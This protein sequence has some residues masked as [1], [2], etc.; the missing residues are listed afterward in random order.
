MPTET[1]KKTLIIVAALNF[2]Y[3][4]VEFGV[5]IAIS[6][7]S[8][9]A[10]SVDFLED[11][12]VNTLIV[13][14]LG[15]SLKRRALVGKIMTF[16]ICL[17]ALVAGIQAIL[18]ALNPVVPDPWALAAT[19]GGAAVVN[20]AC[21]LILMRVRH[22]GGSMTRGA[23]LIARND[24]IVNLLIIACGF[25]T[26]WTASGWPDII[27]G[28]VIIVLNVSAAKEVWEAATEEELAAKAKAGEF[29][30]D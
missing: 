11:A 30:D 23:F 26:Y 14:A 12:F 17:P 6:S 16:I 22:H 13:I 5:A 18:K 2:A 4:F 10:D 29:D 7:V 8:L 1:L 19:A 9:I 25:V 24:V 21:S 15:W 3:F 28:V 20:L 27:L